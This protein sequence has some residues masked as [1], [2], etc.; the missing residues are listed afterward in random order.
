M[1]F[2]PF[3][4]S[5]NFVELLHSQQNV[6]F[7][8]QGRVSLSLSQVPSLGSQAVEL[9]AEC[10]ER[11]TWTVTEDIVLISSW[12]NTS[13]DPVVG[14]DQKSTTFWTRVAA[15][16]S[17]SPKLA[18]CEKR[19]G[20]QCKQRWHKMNEAICKFSG[21]YEAST[22]EKTSGMNDNDIL[23][24]THK[25]FSNNQQK[26][27]SLEHTWNEL[28]NNQKWCELATAKTESSSKRRKFADGSL[29]GSSSQ[30]NE[31]DAGVEGTS[32]P[33][34]V[35]AAKA[36][37]KKP[38]VEGQDVYDCQLMWSIKKDDLAMK[39]QLSKMRLLEKLVAKENLA[40]YEEDLKKKLIN[41]LM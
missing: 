39:Q 22:R 40:D 41:E 17:A 27:F 4:D 25:I 12:L 31:N 19:E 29:S 34:G 23:K 20:T 11:R 36:R 5:A 26:K 14:N 32:R 10:K 7:G 37:G 1:D 3:Q 30:V 18:G 33:P 35:K 2:N 24:L 28:R 16:F 13:K 15:Y 9:P 6:V 8:S 38:Q 21:A